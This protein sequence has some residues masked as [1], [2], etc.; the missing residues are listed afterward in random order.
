MPTLLVFGEKF[1]GYFPSRRPGQEQAV[2]FSERI[3]W[4]QTPGEGYHTVGSYFLISRAKAPSPLQ[5]YPEA[6]VKSGG[7]TETHASVCTVTGG[8]GG[9]APSDLWAPVEIGK[10]S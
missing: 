3:H 9:R 10:P 2:R 8:A 4:V 5:S 6:I 1:Q 7:Y